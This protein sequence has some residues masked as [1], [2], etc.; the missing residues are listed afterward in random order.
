[1]SRLKSTEH[2]STHSHAQ[3]RKFVWRSALVLGPAAV[4]RAVARL[5]G[6]L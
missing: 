4:I 1:M 3:G 2:A 6:A 5:V